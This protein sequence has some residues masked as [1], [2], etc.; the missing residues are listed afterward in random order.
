MDEMTLLSTSELAGL[1]DHTLLHPDAEVGDI[2]RLCEEALVFD[3]A[4]VC[5]NP[6]NVRQC[7]DHLSNSGVGVCTVAGFPLGAVSTAEKVA[8]VQ[9]GLLDGAMEFDMVINLSAFKSGDVTAAVSDIKAVVAAA[10]SNSVKVIIEA[11]LLNDDEKVTAAK[12]VVDSGAHFVKTSTG[13]S[14]GG[15][16]LSDVK[17]LRETVGEEFGVKASG[18]IMGFGHAVSLVEAGASRIGASASVAIVTGPPLTNIDKR[19]V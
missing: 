15:A 12:A 3:F 5:V 1:I 4:T 16:T 11:C 7:A 9:E 8:A 6:V 13:F 18:G 17:L 19:S 10:E 2:S 14:T